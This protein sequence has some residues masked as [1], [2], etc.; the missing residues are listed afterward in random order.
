MNNDFKR[1]FVLSLCL[2]A[3]LIAGFFLA[4][5]FAPT[6]RLD[7]PIFMEIVGGGG[8]GADLEPPPAPPQP[9]PQQPT[10]PP[11]PQPKHEE[12]PK[13]VEPARLIKPQPDEF[14]VPKE[15][16]KPKPPK[17]VEDKP[18][19]TPKKVKTP[20]P[21]AKQTA[22]QDA[23]P[24]T[25]SKPKLITRQEFNKTTA[26]SDKSSKRDPGYSEDAVRSRLAKNFMKVGTYGSGPGPAHDL[27]G[28]AGTDFQA[29]CSMLSS[30]LYEV[31]DIP[32]QATTSMSTIVVVRVTS[33][34][35][36]TFVKILKSSGNVVMDESAVAAV[37]KLR[38]VDPLP[39]S[40]GRV[41][42]LTVTFQPLGA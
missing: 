20:K 35:T 42:E 16:P 22:K 1:N 33:E 21:Q 26:K 24:K 28:V 27:S 38:K 19:E 29:Y 5:A 9:A 3:I 4:M 10:P 41:R 25:E 39:A 15:Q 32:G 34:G 14:A 37:N 30:R 36:L 6:P 8:G 17:K 7:V 12:P 13:P 18:K 23:K 11:P 2:H 40:L 31:W